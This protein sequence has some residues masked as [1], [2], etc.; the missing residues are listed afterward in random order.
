MDINGFDCFIKYVFRGGF[1]MNQ[2]ENS[3]VVEA[4]TISSKKRYEAPCIVEETGMVFTKDI[5]EDFSEGNW[6]FGCTNCN[7][8]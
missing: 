2:N 4:T 6:C 8:N 1:F 5:W 3:W 7:C